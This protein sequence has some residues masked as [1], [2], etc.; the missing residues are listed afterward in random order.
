MII[1]KHFFSLFF[2][3][4]GLLILLIYLQNQNGEIF[5]KI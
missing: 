1:N 3:W 2:L 5:E 4:E